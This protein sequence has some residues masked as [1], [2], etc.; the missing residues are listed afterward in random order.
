M[1]FDLPCNGKNRFHFHLMNMSKYFSILTL[2]LRFIRYRY[3]EE[4]LWCKFNE[5]GMYLILEKYP[6]TFSKTWISQ[7][8]KN[9]SYHLELLRLNRDGWEEGFSKTT[10]KH[11]QTNNRIGQIQLIERR[12]IKGTALAF[13]G[14]NLIDDKVHF[15]FHCPT[16]ST[17]R[18]NFYNKVK[19]LIW[20]ITHKLFDQWTDELL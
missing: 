15:L 11:S 18:N 7:I 13:C 2:T 1:S 4:K 10:N 16:Y 3:G 20:N 19:T 12:R 6:S 14:S 17:L 9:R 5:T 8:F